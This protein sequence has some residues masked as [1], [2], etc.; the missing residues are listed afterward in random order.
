MS[1]LGFGPENVD[2]SYPMGA[3]RL[4]TRIYWLSLSSCLGLRTSIVLHSLDFS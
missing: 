3:F 2:I 1:E 4:F